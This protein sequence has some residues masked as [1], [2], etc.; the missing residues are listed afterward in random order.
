MPSNSSTFS[1]N[2][3]DM[4]K[5]KEI[6]SSPNAK[7]IVNASEKDLQTSIFFAGVHED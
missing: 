2:F 1:S 7:Q 4:R 3:R 5:I 6:L